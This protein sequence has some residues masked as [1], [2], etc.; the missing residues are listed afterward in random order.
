MISKSFFI[1]SFRTSFIASATKLEIHLCSSALEGL[2]ELLNIISFNVF[3]YI[4][5]VVM[6]GNR[7]QKI[8]SRKD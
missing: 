5:Q 4:R 2:T 7:K 1:M 6:A 8:E 3:V